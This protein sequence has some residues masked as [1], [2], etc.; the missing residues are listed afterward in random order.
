MLP[1]KNIPTKNSAKTFI[2]HLDKLVEFLLLTQ[3]LL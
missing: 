3:K 1:V 2:V